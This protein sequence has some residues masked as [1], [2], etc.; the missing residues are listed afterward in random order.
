MKAISIFKI[1]KWDEAEAEGFPEGHRV[2][3]SSII[4]S[5]EGDISGKFFAEYV[6]HYTQYDTEEPHKSV[7][8]FSGV[9]VFEGSVFDKVGSF[10]LEESGNYTNFGPTSIL[11]IKANTGKNELTGISGQGKYAFD[12]EKM[13]FELFFEYD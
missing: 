1:E 4:Y 9:L 2:T 10:A 6:L 13:I 8:T 12:G 3:T 5:V 11:K 7:A